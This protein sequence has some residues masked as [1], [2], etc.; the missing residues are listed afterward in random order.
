MDL[1][2]MLTKLL[3]DNGLIAAFALVGGVMLASV[4]V[5][6]RL[7]MGRVHGSAIAIIVGLALAYWGGTATGGTKGMADVPLFAGLGQ[8]GG[9]M[10]RDFAIVATAFEVDAAEAKKAG[11][12]G[13]IAMAL[14]PF[15]RSWSGPPWP[16]ALGTGTRSRW[17]SSGRGLL[18]TSSDR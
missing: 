11:L 7:T 14:G 13:V 16:R 10:L 3:T 2:E 18:P 12:L 8:L 15:C 6:K 17:R 4:F 5:S 1:H 9:G